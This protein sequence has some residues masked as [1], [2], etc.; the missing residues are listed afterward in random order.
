MP[1]PP[2]KPSGRGQG[3]RDRP[4]LALVERVEVVPAPPAG[5][6]KRTRALWEDFWRSE[7]AKAVELDS[8]GYRLARWI[9]DVD[10]Y[11]RSLAV[12]RKQRLVAGS[13]GQPRLHPLAGR[14]KELEATIRETEKDFGMTPM[15][16]LRL[17]IAVGQAALTAAEVNRLAMGEGDDAA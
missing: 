5:L 14:L 10:E 16:R 13:T 6:L 17:G 3:H 8:D 11:E 12:F 2:R 4:A 9:R 15:S 7:V 1:G